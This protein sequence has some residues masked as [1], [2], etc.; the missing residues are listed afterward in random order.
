MCQDHASA[1]VSVNSKIIKNFLRCFFWFFTC[2][3]CFF[4]FLITFFVVLICIADD[5]STS[6][7]SYWN[8]HNITYMISAFSFWL[9]YQEVFSALFFLNHLLRDFYHDPK[10]PTL[11]SDL[12]Y[13]LQVLEQSQFEQR[14]PGS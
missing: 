2:I 9:L 5:F 6:K 1:A 7:T 10:T 11:N 14:L 13:I 3:D 4:V 12:P 8:Y